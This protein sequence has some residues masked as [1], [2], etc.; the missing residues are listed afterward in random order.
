MSKKEE[1]N[2]EK[3]RDRFNL[4]LQSIFKGILTVI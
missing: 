1:K 4:K 2:K 3:G